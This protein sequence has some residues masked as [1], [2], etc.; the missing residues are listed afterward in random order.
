MRQHKTVDN[1]I[2]S[3]DLSGIRKRYPWIKMFSG[4]IEC[5]IPPGYYDKLL[6]EYTFGGKSD[7][8]IFR[9][10]LKSLTLKPGCRVLELGGGTGRATK[11]FL[12]AIKNFGALD[13]I[14]L[15]PGMVSYLSR[16][17]SR[18]RNVLVRTADNVDYLNK[19]KRKYDL[20]YS[21][22]SFSHSAHQHM[23]DEGLRRGSKYTENSLEGFIKGNINPRGNFFVMHFDSLSEEQRILMKQWAKDF[24]IFKKRSRQSPSKRLLDKIL[25]NLNGVYI[26][27]LTTKYYAGDQILYNSLDELLEIFLNF[28]METEYNRSRYLKRALRD[29]SNDAHKYC[30]PNGTYLI[31]PGCFVYSFQRL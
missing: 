4:D 18:N 11:V 19:T 26:H 12:D 25:K 20:V 13:V 10:Y 3:D 30:Q 17:F 5:Y 14:D 9:L 15:S 16:R 7:L 21:L 1:S 8:D 27:G 6:K 24:H 31:R 22:W 28:H 29:I 23:A 2:S